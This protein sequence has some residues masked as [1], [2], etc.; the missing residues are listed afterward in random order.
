MKT[1]INKYF[2]VANTI[3]SWKKDNLIERRLSYFADDSMFWKRIY[4]MYYNM[5]DHKY[6][7][8]GCKMAL[9]EMDRQWKNV[10]FWVKEN[11]SK[12]SILRDMIYSL[13]R[14]GVSFQEYFMFK[15]YNLNTLGRISF[16]NLKLHYGYSQLANLPSVRDLFEDK[17]KLYE[18]LK[19]FY[20]RDLLVVYGVQQENEL[21]AFLARHSDFIYKPYKGH[22]GI[23]IKVFHG[24][25]GGG[26]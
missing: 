3:T 26:N 18:K 20:K 2:V 6:Y 13:H 12:K 16:S 17:G 21:R 5:F 1:I 19:A 8:N 25:S 11:L 24:Y 7:V 14:F 10:D 4:V 9:K 15:Y 22:S 23:G